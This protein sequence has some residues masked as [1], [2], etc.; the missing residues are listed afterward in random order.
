MRFFKRFKAAC[1][2]G[3][4]QLDR[5]TCSLNTVLAELPTYTLDVHLRAVDDSDGA[6]RQIGLQFDLAWRDGDRSTQTANRLG[7]PS[8][9]GVEWTSRPTAVPP[10]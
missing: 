6:F 1:G 5:P 8:T 7:R 9:D 2:E 10:G 4:S 3:L